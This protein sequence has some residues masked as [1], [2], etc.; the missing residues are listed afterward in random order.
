MRSKLI[1]S[2]LFH[3]Y[4]VA[5]EIIEEAVRL[6]LEV[7]GVDAFTLKGL[8]VQPHMEYS[9][10]SPDIRDCEVLGQMNLEF[11]SKQKDKDFWYEVSIDDP[12]YLIARNDDRN[13]VNLQSGKR[14]AMWRYV[15]E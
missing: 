9:F 3:R 14:G 6:N 10:D 7:L 13:Y 8:S 1:A 4:S 5:V 15:E 2:I 11:L 12:E